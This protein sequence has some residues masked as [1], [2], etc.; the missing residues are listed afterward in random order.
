[1]FPEWDP[2]MKG[3]RVSLPKQSNETINTP[4]IFLNEPP[5]LTSV[6]HSGFQEIP[7]TQK[8]PGNS[9]NLSAAQNDIG[10]HEYMEADTQ[11]PNGASDSPNERSSPSSPSLFGGNPI[12]VSPRDLP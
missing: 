8:I 2:I 11:D 12:G 5:P 9:N 10:S 4:G 6:K 3:S 1:M 7:A